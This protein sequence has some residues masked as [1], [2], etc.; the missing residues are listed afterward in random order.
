MTLLNYTHKKE[1]KGNPVSF[2][3]LVYH[4]SYRIQSD[5]FVSFS[6]KVLRI[7]K[8][9]VNI[10]HKL[11]SIPVLKKERFFFFLS[12]L[13]ILKINKSNQNVIVK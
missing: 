3:N 9:F 11:F 13:L 4:L 1:Y 6:L 5:S 12:F 2:L 8:H 10:L 7:S